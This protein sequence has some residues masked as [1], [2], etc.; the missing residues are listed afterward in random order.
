MRDPEIELVIE[1][2]PFDP[3]VLFDLDDF[4]AEAEVPA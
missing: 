3:E 1:P 2:A 4:L